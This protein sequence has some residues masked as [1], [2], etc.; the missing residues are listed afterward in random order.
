MQEN[1]GDLKKFMKE[2]ESITAAFALV[3]EHGA[4]TLNRFKAIL[5]S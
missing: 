5:E 4:K 2:S 1:P 3:A